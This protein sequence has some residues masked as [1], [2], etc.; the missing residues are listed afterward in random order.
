MFPHRLWRT[1]GLKKIKAFNNTKSVC[2]QHDPLNVT[3]GISSFT[4]TTL[5][6]VYSIFRDALHCIQLF[7]FP[8]LVSS[9]LLL[10]PFIGWS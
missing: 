3:L 4:S 6:A 2:H 7:P 5:T 8:S 1:P 10:F 9:S